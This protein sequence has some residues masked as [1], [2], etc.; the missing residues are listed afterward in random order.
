YFQENTSGIIHLPTLTPAVLSDIVT[1]MYHA[2]ATQNGFGGAAAAMLRV[3]VPNVLRILDAAVYL[4]L[5]GLAEMCAKCAAEN[6]EC[7]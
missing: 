6:F 5:R 1:F 7:Q 4:E 2:W 3:D